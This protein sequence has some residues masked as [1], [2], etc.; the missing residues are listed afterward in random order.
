MYI[1]I[2]LDMAEAFLDKCVT[3]TGKLIVF[4]SISVTLFIMIFVTTCGQHCT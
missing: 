4:L 3:E 1:C 2:Q